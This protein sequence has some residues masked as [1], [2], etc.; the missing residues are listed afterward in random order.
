[1][2]L[3]TKFA[4]KVTIRIFFS[5]RIPITFLFFSELYS[6]YVFLANNFKEQLKKEEPWK[7]VSNK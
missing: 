2:E 4:F 5:S 1:M 7:M 3:K 6:M